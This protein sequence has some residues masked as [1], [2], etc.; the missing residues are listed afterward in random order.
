M[1]FK[2]GI[3]N[4]NIPLKIVAWQIKKNSSTTGSNNES[5]EP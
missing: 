1:L 3:N 2:V 4:N 5:F